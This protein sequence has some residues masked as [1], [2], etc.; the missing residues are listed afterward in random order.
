MPQDQTVVDGAVARR[1][2]GIRRLAYW[3]GRVLQGLGLL[4][5]WWVLLLFVGFADMWT[6]LFWSLAA[7]LIFC[8]GWLCTA[9][10]KQVS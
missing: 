5:I 1:P 6:L 7:T 2:R 3:I 10:A 8:A 4:L 9:W